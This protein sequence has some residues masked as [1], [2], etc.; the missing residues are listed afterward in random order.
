MLFTYWL[1][2][3]V[4]SLCSCELLESSNKLIFLHKF[5]SKKLRSDPIPIIAVDIFFDMTQVIVKRCIVLDQK[6]AILSSLYL[7]I[8]NPGE[9]FRAFSIIYSFLNFKSL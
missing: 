4:W 8:Y 6:E 1:R 3:C 5:S 7:P 9:F 2:L